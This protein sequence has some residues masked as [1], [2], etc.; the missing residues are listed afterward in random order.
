M[1]MM[2]GGEDDEEEHQ[3]SVL[4][5]VFGPSI[6]DE[7]NDCDGRSDSD[8]DMAEQYQRTVLEQ[9]FGHSSSDEEEDDDGRSDFESESDNWESIEEVKG[10]W[11]L[12]NFL[13][14]H[15]QTRL[16]SSIE[17]E[18]WFT[19]P[20][21]NQAMR[22]GYQNLPH[23]AIKLSHSIHRSCYSSS[24]LF[25]PN[26]LQ[27]EPLFDQMITNFYQPG[28]GIAPHVDLLRFEDAIA[29]VSLESSCVMNFTSES[30]SVPVLLTPGSLVFMFG[31]ARYNW[32]HEINRKPGFQSWQGELL[33]QTTRTSV[34]LRKL[35]SS[36]API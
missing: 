23:W 4:E 16:L 20:S 29:I 25:P 10:L 6:S 32:K 18:Q 28:E 35:C 33:N 15:Q 13:S 17:S 22:F 34:T 7:D 27:R 14:I 9:V 5:Q 2:M 30:Q 24:S 19:Q 11:I 1:M 21:I 8:S 12:R 31:D 3:R 26:L 36:A